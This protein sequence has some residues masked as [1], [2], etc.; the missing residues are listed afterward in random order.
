MAIELDKN[1]I[2][3]EAIRFL[4]KALDAKD[5][6]FHTSHF[7][8][9]ENGSA[10]SS[11]G[12]ILHWAKDVSLKPGYYK[13]HKI[14]KTKA[15]IDKVF[16]LDTNEGSFPDYQDLLRIPDAKRFDVWLSPD[17]YA[18]AKAYTKII[19]AMEVSTI[20]FI[21]LNNLCSIFDDIFSVVIPKSEEF[22]GTIQTFKA[23]HLLK[24]DYHVLIMPLLVD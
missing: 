24:N 11:N 16:D 15:L 8:V 1:D 10:V 17:G 4:A 13:V 20:D 9:E 7:K 12:A 22:G 14:T 6:K 3:L 2:R 5:D 19:R 18:P 21:F 23:I